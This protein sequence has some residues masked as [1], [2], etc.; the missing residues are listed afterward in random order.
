VNFNIPLFPHH[1]ISNLRDTLG[2]TVLTPPHR[3]GD[4]R[5]VTCTT[6]TRGINFTLPTTLGEVDLLGEIVGGASYN[7]L[8]PHSRLVPAFGIECRCLGLDR[9]IHVKRAAHRPVVPY[10]PP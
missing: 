2:S 1:Y 9:R 3:G 4:D 7:A 10:P 5:R 8:L 6:I